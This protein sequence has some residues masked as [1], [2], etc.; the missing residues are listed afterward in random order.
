M[1]KIILFVFVVLMAVNV[2]GQR[3]RT[4]VNWLSIAVKGG[5]GNSVFIN[6]DITNDANVTQDYMSLS[7]VMGLRFGITHGDYV[8]IS[9]EGMKSS[10]EQKLILNNPTPYIKTTSFTSIDIAALFRYTSDY[11]F[12][13]EAGPKF[14]R[15][16]S[17]SERNS[18]TGKFLPTDSLF[19]YYTDRP[20]SFI[21]GLGFSAM[22]T[23]RVTLTLG[24]RGTY[25]LDN[26]EADPNYFVLNDGLYIP[27]YVPNAETKPF[28]MQVL[29]ELNYFFGFWGD[30]SC[31]R[32]RLMLFQ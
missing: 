5:F 29:I 19:G 23:D 6:Q 11:G 25:M 4:P 21:V 17:V 22:R 16:D 8:G 13:F 30:A 24:V 2:A 7:K 14:V 1:K 28:T 10:F 27:D 20:K 18:I 32:G 26:F 3:R 15:L 9:I 12:Y 31:G